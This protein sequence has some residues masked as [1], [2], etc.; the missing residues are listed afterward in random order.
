MGKA[1]ARYKVAKPSTRFVKR[2][3]LV[4]SAALLILS[5]SAAIIITALLRSRDTALNLR[6]KIIITKLH[7]SYYTMLAIIIYI[8]VFRKV[9]SLLLSEPL[10][11]YSTHS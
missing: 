8:R 4:S 3:M 5:K 9:A 10:S 6:L 11:T 1:L 7:V 2:S